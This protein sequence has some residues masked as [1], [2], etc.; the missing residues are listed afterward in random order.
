MSVMMVR[1]VPTTRAFTTVR[2][3]TIAMMVT[4]SRTAAMAIAASR[5]FNRFR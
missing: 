5:A 3:G 4:M 1:T 2:T